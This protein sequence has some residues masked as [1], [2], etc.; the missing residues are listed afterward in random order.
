M[1]TVKG[2][3]KLKRI[4]F[5]K[6][7]Y[8]TS[9][10]FAI[11]SFTPVKIEEGAIE[12]HPD[13]GTFSIK[14]QTPPLKEGV[15]YYFIIEEGERHPVFGLGY[16]LA[17]MR[18]NV[19][20]D[21]NSEESIRDFLEI[22]LTKRQV[23]ALFDAFENPIS[24][25]ESKNLEQLTEANGIGLKTA[26]RIVDHYES[27][28]DYSLAY[29]ELG[30]FGL[31][32]KTIRKITDFYNSPELAIQKIKEN[33][34]QLMTIDGFAFKSCDKIFLQ[35][36]GSPNAEIRIKSFLVYILQEEAGKGHTWSTPM[37]LIN[38]TVEFIPEV[39]KTLIGR[40]LLTDTDTFYMTEDKKRISLLGFQKLEDL[41]AKQLH[42]I[43]NAKNDFDYEGWEEF[44]D[45][46]EEA[47]GWKFTEQ[48]RNEAMVMMLENQVSI[49]QGYGGTG[50]TTTLKVSAP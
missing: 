39:D 44:V 50:K 1:A 46:V 27:Q 45:A 10:G 16:E 30:K 14:G 5:P 15:E 32:P 41:V 21:E 4:M 19:N 31:T 35:L 40:L 8:E 43:L 26:Q 48:Q 42:R 49:L 38:A 23:N 9:G 25:I 33:P 6:G 2:T 3:A 13:F 11:A 18:Q 12:T 36:G 29:M 20:L 17:F 24:V 7:A 34:Y 28:K 47:Q 37:D 22:I